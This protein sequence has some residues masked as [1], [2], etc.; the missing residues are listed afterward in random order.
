[1][2]NL[3]TFP[4]FVNFFAKNVLSLKLLYDAGI[5]KRLVQRLD[6]IIAPISLP[7]WLYVL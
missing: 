4:K 1:M 6:V 5:S 3:Y 7:L 2:E